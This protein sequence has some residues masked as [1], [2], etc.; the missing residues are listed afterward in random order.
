MMRYLIFGRCLQ[1]SVYPIM[2]LKSSTRLLRRII[3]HC[4]CYMNYYY[5]NI[6]PY[7]PH[8]YGH[9][10]HLNHIKVRSPAMLILT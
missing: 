5:D 6:Y 9:M 7:M 3:D 8:E 10:I 1:S 2:I 4:W